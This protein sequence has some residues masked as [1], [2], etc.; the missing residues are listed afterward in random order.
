MLKSIVTACLFAVFAAVQAEE[1]KLIAGF[2][3]GCFAKV[4]PGLELGFVKLP[5]APADVI[6]MDEI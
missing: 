4:Y 5:D 2:D 1:P 3:P 6:R